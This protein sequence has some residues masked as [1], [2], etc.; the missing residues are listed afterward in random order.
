M[1]IRAEPDSTGQKSS[2][3]NQRRQKVESW[4]SWCKLREFKGQVKMEFAAMEFAAQRPQNRG[5]AAK[6]ADAGGAG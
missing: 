4:S 2:R 3:Q 5:A 1:E 6:I